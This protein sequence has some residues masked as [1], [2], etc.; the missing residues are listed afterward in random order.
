MPA[1]INFDSAETLGLHLIKNLAKQI[2]GKASWEQ[3]EWTTFKIVFNG[4]ESGKKKYAN[5]RE[6]S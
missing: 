6:N 5:A 3:N 1:N 4:Y 2:E